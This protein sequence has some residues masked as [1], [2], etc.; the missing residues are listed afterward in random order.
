[1]AASTFIYDD[2]VAGKY[3]IEPRNLPQPRNTTFLHEFDL[4]YIQG[5]SE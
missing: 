2:L 5:G 4:A 3:V 1:L